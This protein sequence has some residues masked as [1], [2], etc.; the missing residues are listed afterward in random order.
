M[1]LLVVVLLLT[2]TSLCAASAPDCKELVK[3]FMPED[4]KQVRA[5]PRLK[6]VFANIYRGSFMIF[7]VKGFWEMG[8][9]HGSR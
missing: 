7:A 3:P 9:R 1:A 8:V 6:I 5:A 2:V 4:S